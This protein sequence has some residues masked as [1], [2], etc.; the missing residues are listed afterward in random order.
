MS[1]Q[2]RPMKFKAALFYHDSL[3]YYSV[4]H[5]GKDY[6]KAKLESDM[7]LCA[8]PPVLELRRQ[9]CFWTSNCSEGEIVKELGAAIDQR[10]LDA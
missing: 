7:H 6:Y 1:V 9:N 5:L 8:A 10:T 3:V 2:S 4:Y